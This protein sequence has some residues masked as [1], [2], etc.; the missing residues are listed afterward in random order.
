MYQ[1]PDED[2]WSFIPWDLDATLQL[3]EH[4]W[5]QM[6]THAD[7]FYQFDQTLAHGHNPAETDE[8]PLIRRM[9]KFAEYR[10]AYINT[11]KETL[12][13]ILT[14]E[15]LYARIDSIASRV[16]SNSDNNEYQ[17]FNNSVNET[18]AFVHQRVRYALSILDTLQYADT[19]AVTDSVPP[20]PETT[21]NAL[22]K[23]EIKA[24][25][26]FPWPNPAGSEF[27]I[28]AHL[29]NAAFVSLTMYD[30]NGRLVREIARQQMDA[31][32]Y[33]FHIDISSEKAGIYFLKLQTDS[34]VLTRKLVIIR[35]L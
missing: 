6:G 35:G 19:V 32:S 9:M 17:L 14:E 28:E 30:M 22:Q 5:N 4:D 29:N 34:A 8:R 27:F 33:E 7:L 20:W 12:Q 1:N 26:G 16:R 21:G 13:T 10:N 15:N 18:K 25:L 3:Q 2:R 23:A 31:G 11:Y 24:S